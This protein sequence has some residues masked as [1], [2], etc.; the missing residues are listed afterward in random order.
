M[1]STPKSLRLTI[2]ILGRV[3]TGKSSLLNHIAGQD[4]AIAAPQPGTT[5]D[6]V[7]K[8]M[9][10]APLG[11]VLFLDTEIGRASCRERV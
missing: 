8:P 5:T 2:A 3:N 1:L 9:E 11:P 4:V 7:E 10:F 6:V